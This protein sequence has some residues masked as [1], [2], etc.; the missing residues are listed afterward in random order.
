MRAVLFHAQST[1]HPWI[2]EFLQRAE[3]LPRPAQAEK[4][5]PGVWFLPLPD[6]QNFLNGLCAMLRRPLPNAVAKM[7]EVDYATP[8]QPVAPPSVGIA[9]HCGCSV[10]IPA[11]P[12]QS[13]TPAVTSRRQRPSNNSA[14]A[15][16]RSRWPTAQTC[17]STICR[18]SGASKLT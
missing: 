5:A 2:T 1:S 14:A 11:K 16:P 13:G 7:L 6:R 4:L 8:W 18:P 12:R 15:T 3:G 17:N 9:S 10:R